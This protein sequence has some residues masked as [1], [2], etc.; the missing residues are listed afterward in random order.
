MGRE[1]GSGGF[2]GHWGKGVTCLWGTCMGA[3]CWLERGMLEGG[4]L[5]ATCMGGAALD[6]QG[7]QASQGAPT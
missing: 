6:A 4:M 7:G 5:G 2:A 3:T 1:G